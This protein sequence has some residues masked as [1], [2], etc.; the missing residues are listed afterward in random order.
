MW[1]LAPIRP[2]RAAIRIRRPPPWR[3]QCASILMIALGV[4]AGWWIR[5]RFFCPDLRVTFLAVGEG[6]EA[7]VRFPGSKVMVIDAG[8][9]YPGYDLGERLVAP[10]LWSR[11]IMSVDYL[12][13]SHP[14]LDH[15]G[16]FD[17]LASNSHPGEFWNS[18]EA[19]DDR[20]YT[21]L[22]DKLAVLKVPN[23][24]R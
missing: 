13:L 10:Y 5:D 7:V 1:L 2:P 23:P 4:D 17:Y 24:N 16:G 6:D 15:F 19:S 21:G 22:M 8:G 11:K 18:P 20:S 14:D 3:P 12:A 9:A